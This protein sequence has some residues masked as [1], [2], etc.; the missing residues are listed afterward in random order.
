MTIKYE[1]DHIALNTFYF[2][3]KFNAYQHPPPWVQV[4]L[5]SHHKR[6]CLHQ[7]PST[8]LHPAQLW[9]IQGLKYDISD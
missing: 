8:G 5:E 2:N 9:Y 3:N 6:V 1:D 4:E 7:L